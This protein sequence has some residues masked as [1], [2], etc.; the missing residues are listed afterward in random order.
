MVQINWTHQSLTD[1]ENIAEYISKDS[2]YYAKLQIIKIKNS[3]EILKS[4][5]HV[6][7]RVPEFERNDLKQLIQ[8]RYRIIYKIINENRVD[9][10][11]IHHGS[12]DLTRRKI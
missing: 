5:I 1:L 10:I 12:R 6:G 9:I 8:G 11:T 7:Q 3:V 4:Q 2:K